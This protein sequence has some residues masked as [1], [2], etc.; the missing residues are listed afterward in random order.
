MLDGNTCGTAVYNA[1]KALSI[2][3]Q[4]AD[5]DVTGELIWQTI[6]NTIVAHIQANGKATGTDSGGDSHNLDII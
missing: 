3:G 1:L 2:N 5:A 4:E 6:C